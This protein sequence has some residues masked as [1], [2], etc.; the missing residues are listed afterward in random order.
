MESEPGNEGNEVGREDVSNVRHP[1][2]SGKTGATHRSAMSWVS[3]GWLVPVKVLL[4]R[5]L[6]AMR[7]S[8]VCVPE[9]ILILDPPS[10]FALGRGREEI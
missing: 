1:K 7:G 6:E 2:T 9:K 10:M 5:I 3:S 4:V 8:M